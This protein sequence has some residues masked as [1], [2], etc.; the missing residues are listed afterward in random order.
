M[1]L[2]LPRLGVVEKKKKRKKEK[3][4]KSLRPILTVAGNEIPENGYR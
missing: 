4:K 1:Q 2:A 3:K